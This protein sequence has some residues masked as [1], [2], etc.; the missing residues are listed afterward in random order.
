MFARKL[1][2]EEMRPPSSAPTGGKLETTSSMPLEA[3]VLGTGGEPTTAGPLGTMTE[4]PITTGPPLGFGLATVAKRPS[5]RTGSDLTAAWKSSGSRH[6][7]G[8]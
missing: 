3:T 1:S 4:G 8:H 5:L 2:E 6:I 7:L